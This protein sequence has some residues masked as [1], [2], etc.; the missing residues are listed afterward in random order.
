[1]Q[2]Y[3]LDT[4]GQAVTLATALTSSGGSLTKSGTGTLTLTGANTYGT[5][6]ISTGTLQVGNGGTTG[7]LGSG[8]VTDNAALVFDRSNAFTVSNTISGT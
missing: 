4:N 1:S 8:A 2:A 3:N 7:T 5:T 6:T